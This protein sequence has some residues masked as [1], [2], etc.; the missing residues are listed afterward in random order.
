MV[1]KGFPCY[2]RPMHGQLSA[3]L[4]RVPDYC[5]ALAEKRALRRPGDREMEPDVMFEKII[6][7][8]D[9]YT[10]CNTAMGRCQD[11]CQASKSDLLWS[12][13]SRN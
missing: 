8:S 3:F 4:R 9:S 13:S 10:L 2:L 1:L 12:H 5:Y 7:T 6:Q 11:K